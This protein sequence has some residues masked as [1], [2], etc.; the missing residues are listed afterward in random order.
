MT[1]IEKMHVLIAE[2]MRCIDNGRK[3]RA[4]GKL[5]YLDFMVSALSA[6]ETAPAQH[7]SPECDCDGGPQGEGLVSIPHADSCPLGRWE[8]RAIPSPSH[9]EPNA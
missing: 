1:D 2:I 8:H 6:C 9:K 4:I 5:A 7:K 3:S